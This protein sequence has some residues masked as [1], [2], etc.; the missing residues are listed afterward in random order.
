MKNGL[1]F[2]GRCQH[3]G[4][5][6]A[7]ER[8]LKHYTSVKCYFLSE[9]KARP[10]LKQFFENELA[11]AYLSFVHNVGQIFQN[12]IVALEANDASAV[13]IYDKMSNIMNSLE[14]KKN[15]HFYG[16]LANTILKKCDNDSK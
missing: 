14:S 2:C 10:Y 1:S 5:I 11:G 4:L 6:P 8:L 16:H 7:V 15:E 3:D 12:G 9:A 13:K